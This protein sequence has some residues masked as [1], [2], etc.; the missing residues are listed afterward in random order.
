MAMAENLASDSSMTATL[1]EKYAGELAEAWKQITAAFNEDFGTPAAFAVV[2]EVIRKFN[3]RVRRG[4]KMTPLIKGQ[5]EQFFTFMKT[6]GSL[7]SL[8]QEP[9]QKF[10]YQLDDKLLEKMSVKRSDVDALVDERSRARAAKDFAKA[11]V[12]RKQL[13]EMKIAVSDLNDSSFWE[14]SK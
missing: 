14:V 6:F 13:T 8:L 12:L 7:L 1:D 5:C 4:M 3:S 9:P 2:Y 11:D 10:L